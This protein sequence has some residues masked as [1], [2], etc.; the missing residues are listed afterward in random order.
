MAPCGPGRFEF[1]SPLAGYCL[2][3]H[4]QESI[5]CKRTRLQQIWNNPTS[6]LSFGNSCLTQF[7]TEAKARIIKACFHQLLLAIPSNCKQISYQ[8]DCSWLRR[9]TML[10]AYTFHFWLDAASNC[11]LKSMVTTQYASTDGKRK[12]QKIDDLSHSTATTFHKKPPFKPN[13]SM[14]PNSKDVMLK[15]PPKASFNGLQSIISS[16]RTSI[17]AHTIHH[18]S[19]NKVDKMDEATTTGVNEVLCD[20]AGTITTDLDW[21]TLRLVTSEEMQQFV[22]SFLLI[23]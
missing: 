6:F 4:S 19:Y 3:F 18:P 17:P 22:Q 1:L 13:P 21:K 7:S 5:E 23:H 16:R 10:R 12:K 15:A 8:R 11:Q 2:R 20:S 14:T 9:W